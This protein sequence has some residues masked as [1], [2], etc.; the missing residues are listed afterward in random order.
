MKT[1][2]D[3]EKLSLSQEVGKN[4]FTLEYLYHFDEIKNYFLPIFIEYEKLVYRQNLKIFS[5][6][7][8]YSTH[9][10]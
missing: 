1:N 5:K 7:V 9:F 10:L 6:V 3:K 8:F 4:S 2:S